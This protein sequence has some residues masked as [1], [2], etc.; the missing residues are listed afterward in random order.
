MEKRMV[1][2]SVKRTVLIQLCFVFFMVPL[3][4]NGQ[5]AFIDPEQKQNVSTD[6][7][8]TVM[9]YLD[10]QTAELA[11]AKY[12]LQRKKRNE[13]HRRMFTGILFDEINNDGMSA[14]FRYIKTELNLSYTM[15][16]LYRLFWVGI[17][18]LP[19]NFN[20]PADP[21]KKEWW[22]YR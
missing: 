11:P 6:T 5:A 21:W 3:Y 13:I 14:I 19:D 22:S 7:D 9:S 2:L 12:I 1:V 10:R 15:Q 8:R 17:Y 18:P 16:S 4:S 20:M